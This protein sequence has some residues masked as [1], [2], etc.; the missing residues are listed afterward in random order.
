MSGYFLRNE[1]GELEKK[2][3]NE[4]LIEIQVIEQVELY[5]VALLLYEQYEEV[6]KIVARNNNF[7]PKFYPSI[8]IKNDGVYIYWKDY[9]ARNKAIHLSESKRKKIKGRYLKYNKRLGYTQSS[10]TGAFESEWNVISKFDELFDVVRKKSRFLK[11]LDYYRNLN[12][13][14][15][16][17]EINEILDYIAN[18][19]EDD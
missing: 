17:T 6:I 11:K 16:T 4:M 3:L 8:T 5:N 9:S 2:E 7:I 10:F 18:Q 15:D 14:L 1:Q 19:L 12:D 13:K